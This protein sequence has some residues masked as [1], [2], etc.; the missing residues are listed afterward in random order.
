MTAL[1]FTNFFDNILTT[2]ILLKMPKITQ[3]YP[4]KKLSFKL[5][6]YQKNEKIREKPRKQAISSVPHFGGEGEI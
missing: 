1:F 4:F 2:Q 6:K 5:K 3:N